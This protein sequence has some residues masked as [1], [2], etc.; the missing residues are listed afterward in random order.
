MVGRILVVDDNAENRALLANIL[1]VRGYS[2]TTAP[3]GMIAWSLLEQSGDFFELVITDLMMPR[4]N[5]IE[6]LERVQT[7]YPRIKVVFVTGHFEEEITSRARRLGAFAVLP[8]PCELE[9]LLGIIRR[10][11]PYSPTIE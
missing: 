11:L 5:G 3:D 2:V 1:S 8:R 9:R 7:A 6:L 10:I 4:V